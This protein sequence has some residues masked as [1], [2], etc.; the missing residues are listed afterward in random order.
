M[1]LILTFLFVS[2]VL[3]AQA[4]EEKVAW[5]MRIGQVNVHA[6]NSALDR[7]LKELGM[8]QTK[9]DT[10]ALH[11]NI[12]LSMADVLMQKSTIFVK[13]FGRATLSTVSFRGT[14]PSHTQVTWNGMKINSPMLGMTDFSMIPSYFVDDA[15]LYHGTSSVVVTGGGLG[16]AITLAT[17]PADAQGF[18]LQYIQGIG[19]FQTFDE[20]LRLTYGN[21]HWQS[22][23]RVVYSS[24]PNEYKYT[25]YQK[26][27]KIYDDNQHLVSS[28]YP[29][30]RNKCGAYHDLHILQEVYFN[31]GKGD[32][33]GLSAWYVHS[34]RGVPMLNVDYREDAE[35][36]NKQTE[37][38]LRSVLSWDRFRKQLKLGVKAGYIHTSQGYD[39]SRDLGNG[40]WV[41]MIR[42]RSS[43]NS[44]YGQFNAEYYLHDKWTFTAD[45][46]VHQ[47]F[48]ESQDKNIITQ[49]GEKAVVG[50]DQSRVELSGYLSAKWRPLQRLGF[51][52]TVRED[53]YG[54]DWTPVIPAFF[55]DYVLSKKGNIVLKASVSR[56]YRY[57]TLND[58]YFL[59]GGNINLKPESGFTYDGGISF[60]VSKEQKFSLTGE[61][62]AFDSYIDNW[63]IWLPTFKGFWTPKNVK[64]VHAYGLEMKGNFSMHFSKEW[65]MTLSGT[66]GW[67]PSINRGDPVNEADQSVGKQLPYI[68]LRSAA[69]TG[70]L[71]WR[72][73]AVTY[74]WYHYSERY[75]MSSNEYTITGH[76]SPYFMND[77]MLEKR[78]A[79][80][81]ADLAVKGQVNNIFNE[82][83]ES[84]LSR[85]M[86]RINFEFFIEI[87]PKFGKKKPQNPIH[88][89]SMAAKEIG[90]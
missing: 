13:N 65:E 77:V 32:R 38:T 43:I 17:R 30:E 27:I 81:W 72:T 28:Y 51:A 20:F 34:E 22:S 4:Q 74:K 52:L 69:V 76:I 75:T 18:G 9:F 46:A 73:W 7:P 53:M 42:S 40:D 57:P 80:R 58:Q 14:S 11:E 21:D 10:M 88:S 84:E 78:F 5:S 67:T 66:F 62:T 90:Y 12:A 8:Q 55:A 83:Y 15:T 3:C 89:A 87:R 79:F 86:P 23:T 16:G 31:T 49:Q 41:N 35:Y 39:Y 24:S 2:F 70:R 85:P 63:I 61:I 60:G 44:V 26:K 1:R 47:H 59:P 25:N 45:A 48:V 19:S 54:T 56:N 6:V 82:A 71:S 29:T 64:Q 33:F 50:Y 36:V 68:P 37:Q